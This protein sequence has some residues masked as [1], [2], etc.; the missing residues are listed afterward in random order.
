MLVCLQR[1]FNF[2]LFRCDFIELWTVLLKYFSAITTENWR[3]ILSACV[4]NQITNLPVARHLGMLKFDRNLL[5]IG[6]LN[7]SRY[8]SQSGAMGIR[9]GTKRQ[10][11]DLKNLV[12]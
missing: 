5:L 6:R 9:L 8:F 12:L 3:C 4:A 11:C 1:V 2:L 10:L 7:K